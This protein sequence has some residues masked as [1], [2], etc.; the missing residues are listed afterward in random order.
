MYKRREEPPL[1]ICTHKINSPT[2]LC[3]CVWTVSEDLEKLKTTLFSI[4]FL[5]GIKTSVENDFGKHIA[6]F[7]LN[8]AFRGTGPAQSV[9]HVTLD[10]RVVC[11][12]PTLGVEIT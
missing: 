10:L 1:P 11:S 9:E 12:S 2:T 3:L 8:V 4:N 6:Y 7:Y 5:L